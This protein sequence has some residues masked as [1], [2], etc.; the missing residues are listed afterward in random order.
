[1]NDKHTLYLLVDGLPHR[2]DFSSESELKAFCQGLGFARLFG[3]LT[4]LSK[5]MFERVERAQNGG[6]AFSYI[7][8]KFHENHGEW[9]EEKGEAQKVDR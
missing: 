3:K 1:M 4:F 5:D 6:L 7:A 2:E 8:E 9:P